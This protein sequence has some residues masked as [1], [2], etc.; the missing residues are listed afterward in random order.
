MSLGRGWGAVI[1]YESR[2]EAA[3]DLKA[4]IPQNV[5]Y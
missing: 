3:N 5:V 4:K 2:Q 1:I